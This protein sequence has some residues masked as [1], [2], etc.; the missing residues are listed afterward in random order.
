MNRRMCVLGLLVISLAGCASMPPQNVVQVIGSD[1]DLSTLSKLINDS[2]LNETLAGAGP[3]TV[4]AP[5]NEAFKAVPAK[6]MAE[7]AANQDQLKRVLTY[8]VLPSNPRRQKSRRATRRQ[9]M[10]QTSRWRAPRTT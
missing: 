7:L 10:G 2:G 4:F 9:S 5:T 3:Y 8:H 1:P 6:T